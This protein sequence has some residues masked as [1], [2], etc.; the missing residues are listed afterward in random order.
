MI[1]IV[2]RRTV[3]TRTNSLLDLNKKLFNNYLNKIKI[4]NSKGFLFMKP[5]I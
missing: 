3:A 4:L 2:K 1:N 5:N